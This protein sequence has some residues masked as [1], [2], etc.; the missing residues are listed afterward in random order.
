MET[1]ETE[2]IDESQLEEYEEEWNDGAKYS[3][4]HDQHGRRSGKGVFKWE[5]GDVYKGGFKNNNFYGDG[6]FT[7]SDGKIY[8][9]KWRYNKF[10]GV[11]N[12][13]FELFL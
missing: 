6:V 9:G 4:Q 1:L 10:H 12:P 3:G 2:P 7:W 13:N 5:N 11:N 8:T